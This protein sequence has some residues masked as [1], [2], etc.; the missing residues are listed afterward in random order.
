MK[1]SAEDALGEARHDRHQAREV[2]QPLDGARDPRPLVGPV[3]ERAEQ[4]EARPV[5]EVRAPR[6]L[7]DRGRGSGAGS[8]P[9]AQAWRA[10]A[11]RRRL[12]PA[13][14][15]SSS[16]MRVR[17]PRSPATVARAKRASP[18]L[19][20]LAGGQGL[21]ARRRSPRPLPP[22]RR[23]APSASVAGLSGASAAS[24]ERQRP[25]SARAARARRAVSRS[26][27]ARSARAAA[28]LGRVAHGA[29]REGEGEARVALVRRSL[30]LR[31]RCGRAGCG[32]SAPAPPRCARR[33]PAPRAPPGAARRTAS[34]GAAPGARGA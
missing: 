25:R 20:A 14:S 32:T 22:A 13:R 10:I 33:P 2:E 34:S 15:P 18:L 23:A 3:G 28:V 26:A 5:A 30:G 7:P 16:H 21:C 11:E 6:A 27:S 9:R 1:K 31:A 12:S 19:R 17:S 29:L 8:R 4:H 24:R